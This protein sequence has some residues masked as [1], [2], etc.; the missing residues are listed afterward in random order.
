[1]PITDEEREV[2]EGILNGVNNEDG[3]RT[4]GLNDYVNEII[5]AREDVFALLRIHQ[6]VNNDPIENTILVNAKVRARTAAQNLA[7]LLE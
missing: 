7:T 2:I 1:M 3:T 5:E 4:N 6:D